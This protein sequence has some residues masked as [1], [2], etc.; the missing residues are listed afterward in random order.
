MRHGPETFSNFTQSLRTLAPPCAGLAEQIEEII[1]TFNARFLADDC[2]A[3]VKSDELDAMRRQAAVVATA[4]VATRRLADS[5]DVLDRV[6][7][8]LFGAGQA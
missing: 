3:G 7:G 5:L 2:A 4:A 6:Y 1:A 8:K